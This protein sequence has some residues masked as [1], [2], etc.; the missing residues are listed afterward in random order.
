[1]ARSGRDW[2][3]WKPN[4]NGTHGAKAAEGQLVRL[5]VL[6]LEGP[7][8]SE[9]ILAARQKSGG[10]QRGLSDEL[11]ALAPP[12]WLVKNCRSVEEAIAALARKPGPAKPAAQPQ[13]MAV[14]E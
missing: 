11:Q 6:V 4:T 10:W 2:T 3:A 13:C 5:R 14:V 8:E 9:R 1:M 7:D 12:G